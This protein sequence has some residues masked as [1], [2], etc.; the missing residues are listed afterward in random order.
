MYTKQCKQ[1]NGE[2]NTVDKNNEYC[3]RRCRDLNNKKLIYGRGINDSATPVKVNNKHINSYKVW[4]SMF[5]RCYS[6][7]DL[8]HIK[9]YS[10]VEVCNEW[11]Y[12][13]KFLDW[14][15]E[16]YVAGYVLDKDICNTTRTKSYCA[17]NCNFIPQEINKIFR[18]S[19]VHFIDKT[20]N[21]RGKYDA[22]L[23]LYGKDT[24]I[25]YYDTLEEAFNIY[26]KEKESYIKQVATEYY[27]NGKINE[28]VY[29]ALMKYEV[30]ITD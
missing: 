14:Y 12:Y 15:N 2:F 29:Q 27:S 10:D 16:H 9:A 17:E 4:R 25:G 20:P 28:R 13:S 11:W 21:K 19:K 3:C 6:N 8:P 18:A 24:I 22:R 30:A 23:S 1:C 26:K 5:N 7:N